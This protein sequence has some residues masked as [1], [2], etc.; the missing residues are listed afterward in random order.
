MG[1]RSS[2]GPRRHPSP[3]TRARD[4]AFRALDRTYLRTSR[5]QESAAAVLGL[6]FSTYRRHLRQGLEGVVAW[7]WERELGT[8]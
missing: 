4:K 7:L 1:W 6:P 3:P 8:G 5:T 2:S